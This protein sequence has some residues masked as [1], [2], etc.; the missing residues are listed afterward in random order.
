[1]SAVG[2][3]LLLAEWRRGLTEM[4]GG[5]PRRR[6]GRV[7]MH[8]VRGLLVLPVVAVIVAATVRQLHVVAPPPSA[9]VSRFNRRTPATL[10][11]K[12]DEIVRALI[13]VANAAAVLCRQ[14]CQGHVLTI[15]VHVGRLLVDGR[16]LPLRYRLLSLRRGLVARRRGRRWRRWRRLP[17]ASGLRPRLLLPVVGRVPIVVVGKRRRSRRRG[18]LMGG[19][20]QGRRRLA[21]S[22]WRRSVLV[23]RRRPAVLAGRQLREELRNAD[24]V[25]ARRRRSR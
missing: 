1:M 16:Q 13:C 24:L 7:G 18:R 17:V 3:L 25:P 15:L 2:R 12:A 4:T 20:R 22:R 9:K 10:V 11:G 23:R 8:L 14:P 6:R 5:R 19:R 21:V